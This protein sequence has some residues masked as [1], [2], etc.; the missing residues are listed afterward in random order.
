VSTTF[1]GLFFSACSKVPD[2]RLSVIV[3]IPCVLWSGVRFAR[4]ARRWEDPMLR[5]RVVTTTAA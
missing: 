3:A 2:W 4:T 5:A 1:T